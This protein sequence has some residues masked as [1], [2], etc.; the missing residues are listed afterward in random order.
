[1]SST[2]SDDEDGGGNDRGKEGEVEEAVNA[3]AVPQ[4]EANGQ[5]VTSQP[6]D[7]ELRD[8]SDGLFSC[9]K[10]V[11]HCFL[12]AFFSPCMACYEFH[13]HNENPLLG[14]TYFGP[15]MALVA[16][17]RARNGITGSLCTDCLMSYFCTSC[18]LCRLHRD[19]TRSKK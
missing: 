2:S 3:Q 8:W 4:G 5:V 6:V 17:Y 1:M 11:G 9:H 19:F 13:K 18:M 10:D 16:Q 7:R 14:C 15:L 12:V